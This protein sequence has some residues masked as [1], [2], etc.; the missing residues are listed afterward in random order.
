MSVYKGSLVPEE[1]YQSYEPVHI[2]D[3]D[4][5]LQLGRSIAGSAP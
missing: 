1:I 2:F 4:S 5:A 3:S